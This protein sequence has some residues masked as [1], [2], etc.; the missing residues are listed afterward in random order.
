MTT[1]KL[2]FHLHHWE[3]PM[4]SDFTLLSKVLA[5]HLFVNPFWDLPILVKCTC[6]CSTTLILAIGEPKS[7]LQCL[8]FLCPSPLL[9]LCSST[10]AVS[11]T[12]GETIDPLPVVFDMLQC[13]ASLCTLHTQI[14]SVLRI[15]RLNVTV[16]NHSPII[17]LRGG[18]TRL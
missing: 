9:L 7:R 2:A 16:F 12:E 6:F 1:S 17:S 8:V 11:Q 5:T 14:Q 18:Y 10:S 4:P 13:D 3:A 15:N